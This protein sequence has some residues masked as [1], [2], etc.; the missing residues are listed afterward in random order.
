MK[1]FDIFHPFYP[2]YTCYT[3]YIHS[4]ILYIFYYNFNVCNVCNVSITLLGK[5]DVLCNVSVTCLEINEGVIEPKMKKRTKYYCQKGNS[6]DMKWSIVQ[7]SI[8]K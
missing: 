1:D 8:T 4:K 6:T 5:I 3:P 2:R 7:S